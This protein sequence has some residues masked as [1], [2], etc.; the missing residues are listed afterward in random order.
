MWRTRRIRNVDGVPAYRARADATGRIEIGCVEELRR[1][2]RV[3]LNLGADGPQLLVVWTRRGP[4]VVENRC[5]HWP[6]RLDDAVVRGTVL[7]CQGHHRR[8]SLKCPTATATPGRLR[9]YQAWVRDSILVIDLGTAR[10]ADTA[11]GAR[12]AAP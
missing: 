1:R 11:P 8:F 2:R 9:R 3:I 7:V 12:S 4:Y 10:D 5:P 6:R